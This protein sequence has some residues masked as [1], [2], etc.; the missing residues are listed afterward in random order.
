MPFDARNLRI[1]L[2][3]GP[4]TV[5]PCRFETIFCNYPSRFTCLW[6]S[7][8]WGSCRYG[9]CPLGSCI[10][11]PITC[12]WGS[13]ICPGSVITTTPYET[14]QQVTHVS[15]EDLGALREQLQA[16]LKEIDEA[17]A[18]VKQYEKEQG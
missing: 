2:P 3:C 14:I 6:G 13:G 18:K 7:C 4:V 5:F 11:S 12:P 16:Q 10:D 15:V 1:Q 9:S 8:S 17:E